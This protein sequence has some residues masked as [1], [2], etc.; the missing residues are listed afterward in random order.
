MTNLHDRL[1]TIAGPAVVPSPAQID[2]D[3]ARGKRALRRRRAVQQVGASV[4]AVAAIAAAVAYGTSGGA[5]PQPKPEAV[6]PVAPQT[7]A[8]KLVAYKGEQPKGFTIDKVPDGWEVQGVSPGA[9]TIAPIG[10]KDQHPDSFVGKIAV[11]LQ[12]ADDKSTPT[13]QN[14]TVG[15]KP[16]VINDPDDPGHTRNLWVKQ[17]NGIWMLVQIWDAR[18]WTA[19]SMVE[20]ADGITVTK[21]AQQ[22]R[23]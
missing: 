3:L 7:V 10:I 20:F 9:L 21:E 6:A 18:G 19:E 2:A 5:S 14:V 8:T 16:G 12:S 4:F 23:G 11:M 1:D 13:G 17:P 15:G 22:G